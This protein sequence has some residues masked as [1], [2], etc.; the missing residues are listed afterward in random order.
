M[1]S[2]V[3]VSWQLLVVNVWVCLCFGSVWL[4][5]HGISLGLFFCLVLGFGYSCKFS[6]LAAFA[7]DFGFL[8]HELVGLIFWSYWQIWCS[9][10][11]LGRFVFLVLMCCWVYWSWFSVMDGTA[12]GCFI[13][14]LFCCCY[15]FYDFWLLGF[16]S[17][18]SP[19]HKWVASFFWLVQGFCR[20]FI[21]VCIHGAL[22]LV[23]QAVRCS[24]FVPTIISSC[25]S[26][27]FQLFHLLGC[28]VY[29]FWEFYIAVLFKFGLP[30]KPT[31]VLQFASVWVGLI[32][33]DGLIALFCQL[34]CHGF[35]ATCLVFSFNYIALLSWGYLGAHG[36]AYGL[37]FWGMLVGPC[38]LT[39]VFACPTL[40]TGLPCLFGLIGSAD[41]FCLDQFLFR[42]V[43]F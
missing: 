16:L 40:W 23:L 25:W 28:F 24:F 43:V 29:S 13:F 1:I 19:L 17:L 12:L 30:E 41:K 20:S 5:L 37:Q 38:P 7:G 22:W 8:A 2:W 27:C 36:F 33:A 11:L 3:F 10:L 31:A 21:M 15:K 4:V 9:L 35:W 39:A 42:V 18:L 32:S 14:S 26:C 34:V 6:R